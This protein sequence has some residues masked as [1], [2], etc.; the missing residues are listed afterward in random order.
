MTATATEIKV[1]AQFGYRKVTEVTDRTVSYINLNG[2]KDAN[3]RKVLKD[4]KVHTVTRGEFRKL[5]GE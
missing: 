4:L 3:G 5:I 2:R 1:G